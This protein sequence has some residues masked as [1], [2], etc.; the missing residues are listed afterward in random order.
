MLQ[1]KE[2]ERK[3]KVSKK[4]TNKQNKI[5]LN[6]LISIAGV[7]LSQ[8][9]GKALGNLEQL[10]SRRKREVSCVVICSTAADSLNVCPAAAR[11]SCS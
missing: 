2:K 8:L 6:Y 11:H 9:S 7:L 10:L 4:E 1:I 5:S 3:R